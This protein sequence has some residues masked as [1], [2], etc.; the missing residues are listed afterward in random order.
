MKS[1]EKEKREF[2]EGVFTFFLDLVLR[3]MLKEVTFLSLFFLSW[4]W[5]SEKLYRITILLLNGLNEGW[6][7]IYPFSFSSRMHL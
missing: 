3:G 2:Y 4:F 7:L 5:F 6:Y 1:G